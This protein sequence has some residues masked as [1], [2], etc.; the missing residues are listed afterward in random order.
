MVY[1]KDSL[2]PISNYILDYTIDLIRRLLL[3]CCAN[4]SM[5]NLTELAQEA[6]KYC[7]NEQHREFEL[8]GACHENAIGTADYIRLHTQYDP[9]IVWG[10]VTHKDESDTAD[11]VSNVSEMTTHFWVELVDIRSGIID[12]HTNNPLAGDI[13]QYIESGIAYGGDQP[14]C[15]NTVEKF[16]YYGQLKYQDLAHKDNFQFARVGKAVEPLNEV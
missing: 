1:L 4:I 2:N 7:Q 3:C 10:V 5:V 6:R 8:D 16:V 15:Y 11:K 13:S 14:D 12:V 9:V